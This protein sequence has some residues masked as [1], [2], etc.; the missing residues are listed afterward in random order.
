MKIKFNSEQLRKAVE[1]A[2]KRHEAKNISFRNKEIYIP[3][4]KNEF[5]IPNEY[6]P[7]LIG[8][9][10]EM[11]WATIKNVPIDENIYKVRDPGEDFRGVEVKA[12]TYFGD[13]E[14]ELKIKVKE[15]NKKKPKLYVLIRVDP[16]TL[17]VELLGKIT[18]EKFSKVKTT[19]QYGPNLPENY[20]VK[21][22]QMDRISVKNLKGS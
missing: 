21:V 12:T 8:V 17:E 9:L 1:I 3:K 13:G 10:G 16:N 6:A 18:R 22:S 14:P 4:Q 2:I 11:A 15:F 19:K 20:I 5:G 7:H